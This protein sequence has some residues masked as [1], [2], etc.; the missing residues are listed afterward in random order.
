MRLYWKYIDLVVQSL[1]IGV[2]SFV[3]VAVII[4]SRSR[5]GD[6]PL[7]I[8]SI[9]LILGPW[10]L[11]GSLIAVFRGTRSQKLKSIHLIASLLYLAILIPLFQL[12]FVSKSTAL[13]FIT[14][15]AW[16]LAFGYY[17]ITW[18]EVL[19]KSE[20]GKGFLPHLGF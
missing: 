3:V 6:W 16:I 20:R 17:T 7:V 15:P 11:I 2:A 4:G 12:G 10:Q 1:C 5:E 13:P 9:Q 8:L 14:V 18:R 19:K